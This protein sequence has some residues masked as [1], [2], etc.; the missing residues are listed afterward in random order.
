MIKSA[1]PGKMPASPES[2]PGRVSAIVPELLRVRSIDLA[3][4]A[5]RLD[6]LLNEGA[7]LAAA[8]GQNPARFAGLVC[9][10]HPLGGGTMNNKVVY[11]A[12]KVL[13]E[14]VWGFGAPVLRFNF[15]GTGT[16]EGV[17]DGMAEVGDVTAA[18]DWLENE[19]NLP[20]VVAGFSFGAVMALHAC[21]GRRS[22]AALALLSFPA[23]ALGRNYDCSALAEDSI[24]TLFL[25]G[26]CDAF[27]PAPE[28]RAWVQKAAR[29]VRL[30]LVRGADHFFSGHLDA[31]QSALAGWLKE[32]LP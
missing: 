18:L 31:M 24:P 7:G 11:H 29:P 2:F 30:T 12:T 1:E 10:P 9:H 27:A 4:P 28:L 22:V 14:P 23:A 20:V 26:D 15:R 16:S 17:H 8:E 19:Y 5:G 13:N 3:G 32:Q 21:C 25:S 6:A